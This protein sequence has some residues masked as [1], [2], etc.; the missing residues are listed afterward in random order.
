MKGQIQNISGM[1]QGEV[2]DLWAWTMEAVKY[3]DVLYLNRKKR[4]V[5]KNMWRAE[6]VASLGVAVVDKEYYGKEN[7]EGIPFLFRLSA[8]RKDSGCIM[9]QAVLWVHMQSHARN[10]MADNL[11]LAQ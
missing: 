11:F 4:Q 3:F 6:D 10:K 7:L 1:G 8:T 5:L 2:E 9:Y